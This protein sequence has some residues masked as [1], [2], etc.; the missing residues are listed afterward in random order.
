M[1][2]KACGE[3]GGTLI[4]ND[5]DAALELAR[6]APDHPVNKAFIYLYY[7]NEELKKKNESLKENIDAQKAICIALVRSEAKLEAAVSEAIETMKLIQSRC[8]HPDAAQGCRNV[9]DTAQWYLDRI[10]SNVEK[11]KSVCEC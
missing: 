11:S 9:I 3:F 6:Y 8:G 2:W 4:Q 10:Y 1:I 7:E 5:I